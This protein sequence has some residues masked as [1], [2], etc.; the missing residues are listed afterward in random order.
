MTPWPLS[1]A[2]HALLSVTHVDHADRS[3]GAAKNAVGNRR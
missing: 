3:L 2:F 1:G